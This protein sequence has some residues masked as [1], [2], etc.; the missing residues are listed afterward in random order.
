[1]RRSLA[2]VISVV[3]MV[4]ACGG[5]DSDPVDSTPPPR[6]TMEFEDILLTAG[7]DECPLDLLRNDEV[8]EWELEGTDQTGQVWRMNATLNVPQPGSFRFEAKDASDSS[9]NYQAGLGA[10]M[11]QTVGETS[12][13]YFGVFFDASGL[14][15]DLTDYWATT[16]IECAG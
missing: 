6:V 7:L 13:V 5:D 11:S 1:M 9:P 8:V 10:P 16:T 2:M 15:G 12:A 3:L 4:G 14:E